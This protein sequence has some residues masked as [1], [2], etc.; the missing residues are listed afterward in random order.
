MHPARPLCSQAHDEKT[1]SVSP[2]RSPAGRWQ[3]DFNAVPSKDGIGSETHCPGRYPGWRT[4]PDRLPIPWN[5]GI[6]T[7]LRDAAPSSGER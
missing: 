5:S 3:P 7:D 1:R 2:S 4:G 6:W